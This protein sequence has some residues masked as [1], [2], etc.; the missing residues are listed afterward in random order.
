M[1]AGGFAPRSWALC[2]GQLLAVSQNDALFSL[3]GTIYGGD[4]R[5]TFGLPD[6]RGRIPIHAGTGPGLTP[7]QIGQ[8]SGTERVTLTTNQLPTH[9][10]VVQ[11]NTKTATETSPNGTVPAANSTI[12]VYRS[13][14]APAPFKKALNSAAVQNTGG[15]QPHENM[16]PFLCVNF[17]CALYGVYPSRT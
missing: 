12:F 3:Y 8:K 6:M 14:T 4:G 5:T 15:S 2:D 7:R 17:I 1:F 9:T 10:H 16:Q 11:A 13:P